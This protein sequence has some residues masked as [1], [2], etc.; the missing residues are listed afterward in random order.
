MK[1]W[2]ALLLAAVMCLSLAACG[3]NGETSHNNQNEK[4]NIWSIV[5]TVDDFGDVVDSNVKCI[6]AVFHGDFSNTATNSSDLTVKV[7]ARGN[8]L[9]AFGLEL[10]EYD[11]MKTLFLDS[12]EI[13]VKIKVGDTTTEYS[14]SGAGGYIFIE[15]S[16][17]SENYRDY[18]PEGTGLYEALMMGNDV[19]V[20]IEVG[21]S[22]YNFTVE[23]GNFNELAT[24]LM[25]E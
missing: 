17:W 12:N 15:D 11:D 1:K 8:D 25:Q 14:A 3:S 18:Y 13:T 16:R 20:V 9:S 24:Q 19:R 22:K 6:G 2:I 23:A 10:L 5:Q 4:T 7:Y 21:S